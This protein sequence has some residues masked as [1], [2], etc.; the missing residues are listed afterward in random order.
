M[1]KL[2]KRSSKRYL[3]LTL[4]MIAVQLVLFIPG[5]GWADDFG[6]ALKA[7]IGAFP[8]FPN[9]IGIGGASA[10]V[11]RL[12]SDNPAAL[13][14]FNQYNLK[15][16]F[17]ANPNQIDF[18][19]G[20]MA[21]AISSGVLLPLADGC[22]KI[23]YT[24]IDSDQIDY[25]KQPGLDVELYSQEI[26]VH[27]GRKIND[28]ISLGLLFKPWVKNEV[29]FTSPGITWR[30]NEGSTEFNIRPGVLYQP[31]KGWY[32][33]LTYEYTGEKIESTILVDPYT[34]TTVKTTGNSY[35]RI[36]RVG[37]SW[38]P[39]KG[40][41]LAFDWLKGEIDGTE[42][43]DYDIDMFFFGI[44]QY[45]H[46]NVVLRIGSLDGSLTAG[47]GLSYKKLFLNYSYI[48]ES[49][50]DLNPYLGSSTTHSVSASL[51]F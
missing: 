25:L 23:S 46:P 49:L 3:F 39:K 12:S 29:K 30:E 51:A 8:P 26:K 9:I 35:S 17:F 24:L 40:T 21:Y 36:W 22:L 19:H 43:I 11:P 45:V 7:S 16:I 41:L 20:P 2:G 28:E 31:I 6:S 10:A 34:G 42:N 38:Q 5:Q 4:I 32:L 37:T 33:G 15:A 50:K 44:E 48:D 27:Y 14:I 1:V 47:L 13:S 18:D